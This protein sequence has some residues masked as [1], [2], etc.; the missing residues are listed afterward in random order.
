MGSSSV[1]LVSIC[2]FLGALRDSATPVLGVH[3]NR[4]L[5]LT[6]NEG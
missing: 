4:I 6:V 2:E 3:E 1:T 5:A